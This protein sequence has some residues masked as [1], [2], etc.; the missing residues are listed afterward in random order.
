MLKDKLR[1]YI[2]DPKD[3][4]IC[5]ELGLEYEKLGQTASA[6][7]LYLR[8]TEFTTNIELSYEA[9]CRIGLCFERQGNRWFM[10]KGIYLRAISLLPNRPEANFLLCRAYERCKDWQEG[11]TYSI[12]GKSL[13]TSNPNSITD[14]EYPGIQAFDFQKGV[15]AW[16]IGLFQESLQIMR[17]VSVEKKL[18]QNY[19][20]AAKN[21]LLNLN[22]VWSEPIIYTKD[23]YKKLRYKFNDSNTI[24]KNYSQ[25]FQDLFVLMAT[26]GL[27]NG[28]W[29]EIGCADP[30]YGNNTKLL[31]EWGWNGMS[32]DLDNT[33]T[34]KWKVRNTIPTIKDATKIDWENLDDKII[35]YLQIDIDPA[36]ISY[37]VL[38]QIPF[39]KT[40]FRVIT[41]EHDYYTREFDW[42]REKSRKYLQS[43]GYKLIVSNVSPNLHNPYEDWWIHP[44]LVEDNIVKKL[45]CQNEVTFIEDWIYNK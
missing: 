42:V 11:Y 6:I 22:N 4:K 41:F 32:I 16:W 10:I 34:E 38:T 18:P 30:L 37:K 5:F 21:N 17:D 23:N 3:E 2:D 20:Q 29:I 13:S 25:S 36:D 39:W 44:E 9:L 33:Q 28:K 40:K 43:F 24:E 31:E 27:K 19:L 7:G 8:A 1:K 14:L 15:C 26:N 35:D 12:T 45:Y